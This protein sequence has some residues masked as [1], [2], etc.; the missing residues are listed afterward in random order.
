[1]NASSKCYIFLVTSQ[2]IKRFTYRLYL[3]GEARYRQESSGGKGKETKLHVKYNSK[4]I[5][6]MNKNQTFLFFEL[7]M[8]F[9]QV[10]FL[11]TV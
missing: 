6:L 11:N 8:T 4:Y 10:C 3:K 1:M 7:K 5:T 9:D 2:H